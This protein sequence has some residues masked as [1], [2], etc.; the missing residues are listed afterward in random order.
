MKQI[1]QNFGSDNLVLYDAFIRFSK[2][3]L[4]SHY[5]LITHNITIVMVIMTPHITVVMAVLTLYYYWTVNM[6]ISN[7]SRAYR[8]E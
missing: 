4:T 3:L 8:V 5:N 2:L 1:R 7:I 6:D